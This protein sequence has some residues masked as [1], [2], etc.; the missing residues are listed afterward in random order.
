MM[1]D[2]K[3]HRNNLNILTLNANSVKNKLSELEQLLIKEVQPE[4]ICLQET[5]LKKTLKLKGY[6]EA[7]AIHAD[8]SKGSRGNLILVRDGITFIADYRMQQKGIEQVG[9]QLLLPGTAPIAVIS[10]Y[11]SPTLNKQRRNNLKTTMDM[12][13]SRLKADHPCMVIGD[14]NAKTSLPQ[15]HN[16][17]RLGEILDEL[18]EEEEITIHAPDKYTRF[19]PGGRAPSTIDVL[20]TTP[21][22]AYLVERKVVHEDV[23]SDHRPISFT[24]NL[25]AHRRKPMESCLPNLHKADWIQYQQT[26]SE[27][28]NFAPTLAHNKAS[29]DA[30][31]EFITKAIKEADLKS[32]PRSKIKSGPDNRALPPVIVNKIKR[33]RSLRKQ[34]KR[35]PA[36]KKQVNSLGREIDADIK[37]FEE[38]KKKRLWEEARVKG[39]HEFYKVAQTYFKPKSGAITYPI[40]NVNNEYL[41]SDEERLK[42][43]QELYQEIYSPPEPHPEHATVSVEADNYAES[44]DQKYERVE[45][46][47]QG[48]LIITCTPLSI[49]KSLQKTKNTS[50]GDDGVFYSHIK[51]LP[52]V[53]L[54][55]LARLYQTAWECCYFPDIWKAGITILL[56]KSG[57]ER[58]DPKNYR[59]ITL[60]SALG[61]TFERFVNNELTKSIEAKNIIPESQAGF[62]ANRS[63]H[64]Q[65]FKIG[66]GISDGFCDSKITLTAMYDV[67]KSY[68]K[69][70]HNGLMLKMKGILGET[71][72]AFLRNYL[73]GRKIHLRINQKLSEPVTLR[74]GTAQGSILSPLIHNLWCHDVP[75]P[76]EQC[77]KISQFAD[78]LA[79]WTTHKSTKKAERKLQHYN[80]RIARWCNV[81][82]IKL[83]VHKTQCTLFHQKRIKHRPVLIVNGAKIVAKKNCEFL[84]VVMDAKLTM[85]CQ[86]KKIEKEIRTRTKIFAKIT[87]S[88]TK[89]RADTK[90][91]L[92]I[93]KAMIVP[94]T[95][96]APSILC[97]A[98]PSKL[99][100]IDVVLRKATRLAIHCPS[101][102][103]NDYLESETGIT[104]LETKVHRLARKYLTNPQ[105]SSSVRKLVEGYSP[106]INTGS[107]R[108]ILG[109]ILTERKP[110]Q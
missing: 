8:H 21:R 80:D 40:K 108:T 20:L 52:N 105:R 64:D 69:I 16:T 31:V 41:T 89:P 33:K 22:Y 24:I 54:E 107:I 4:V 26:M 45:E 70:W 25:R 56:P 36:L 42:Q 61:K 97:L 48:E 90:T 12:V 19:D 9:I 46:R 103:R 55:Y 98:E 34:A 100:K 94:I 51:H 106:R 28:M 7:G 93:L 44:L 5:L 101:M 23:G 92:K 59:P 37:C 88:H 27:T 14:L 2:R 11:L 86:L 60:L 109:T 1:D 67:E 47:L 87:G 76:S 17:N 75:Q 38:Q 99:E 68:D 30:S 15:H 95:T 65:L 81:W 49:M 50:P 96:Y 71:T 10:T 73:S 72:I 39:P 84:G 43:F 35:C 77:T 62:R 83:S 91:C 57:K 18:A 102:T 3:N 74:A 79:I 6:T 13:T 78:D 110:V 66:E 58:S 82:R 29:I 53:A 104:N 32:I 85:K 63:T